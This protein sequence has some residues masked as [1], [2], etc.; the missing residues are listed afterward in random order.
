MQGPVQE[1]NK[2]IKVIYELLQQRQ[3]DLEFRSEMVDKIAKVESDK[4]T[5]FQN[6]VRSKSELE[7]LKKENGILQNNNKTIEKK[8]KTE[9]EKMVFEKEEIS[10]QLSKL[11]FKETQMLHEIRKKEN[12]T[13]KYKEQVKIK[14]KLLYIY[15]LLLI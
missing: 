11:S 5:I 14:K 15:H 1:I 7:A 3:R 10:K 12:E 2:T 9:K 6:L 4:S 13:N 8:F